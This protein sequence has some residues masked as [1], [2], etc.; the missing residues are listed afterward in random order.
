MKGISVTQPW[1]TLVSLGAKRYE[2]RSWQTRYRGPL[3]IHASKGFPTAA[4]RLVVEEPHFRA[5]LEKGGFANARFM[6]TGAVIAICDL[7]ACMPAARVGHLSPEEYS[8]GDFSPGRYAWLLTDVIRLQIPI[9]WTGALS[10][11]DVPSDLQE[12]LTRIK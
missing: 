9:P 10:L 6:P 1:A 7:T 11:W 12:K 2:T 5:A 4:K 8:F 3:L